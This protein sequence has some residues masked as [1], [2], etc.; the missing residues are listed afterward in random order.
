ML[1]AC[2]DC[3]G[4]LS[5][6]LI[7]GQFRTIRARAVEVAFLQPADT[8]GTSFHSR[9]VA[10][11][12]PSPQNKVVIQRGMLVAA[13]C[14]LLAGHLAAAEPAPLNR[15]F[16]GPAT[17]WELVDSAGMGRIQAQECVSGG[18][19]DASGAERLVVS[20]PPGQTV[21]LY[22]DVVPAA[23][24][25]ELEL[26]MW[27]KASLPNT[28]LAARIVLPRTATGDGKPPATVVVRGPKYVRAG[29]WQQLVFK[30][31]PKSLAAEVRFLRSTSGDKLETREAYLDAVFLLV[32]GERQG[33]EIMTDD[34]VIDGVIQTRDDNIKLTSY[35]ESRRTNATPMESVS[36]NLRRLPQA[37]AVPVVEKDSAICMRN[38]VLLVNDRPFMPRGIRWRGEPFATLAQMGFNTLWLDEMPSIEQSR[39]AKRHGVWFI[40]SPPRPEMLVGQ[41]LGSESDRILAWYLND[42][43]VEGDA[44]YASRWANGVRQYDRMQGR[45]ILMPPCVSMA[46][47]SSGDIL[48]APCALSGTLD[49][50]RYTSLLR[51]Y[52]KNVHPGTPMWPLL[53][54]QYGPSVAKQNA[55]L[56]HTAPMAPPSVS[57][58]QL[59][60]MVRLASIEGARGFVFDSESS[61][62]ETDPSTR[63]RAVQLELLNRD[64]Q[65]MEPWLASGKV[66][67]QIDSS[68]PAWSAMEFR[69]EQ[70]RLLVLMN[71]A[72]TGST[73]GE[74]ISFV[75][76]GIPE[77]CQVYLYTPVALQPL[78]VRRIAGGMQFTLKPSDST[79]VLLT[80]DMRVVQQLR[81]F[82][83]RY[84]DRTVRLERESAAISGKSLAET[85]HRLNLSGND[86]SLAQ[87]MANIN[88]LVA[89]GDASLAA[90]QLGPAHL[91][92]TNA[93]RQLEQS[94]REVRQAI[95]PTHIRLS[96]PQSVG[97]EALVQFVAFERSRPSLQLGE[98]LLYGGDFE[99]VGQLTQIGWQHFGR[100][101]AGV[102]SHVELSMAEPRHGKYALLM[103]A[104]A[105]GNALSAA[106]EPVSWIESPP[107]V[108]PEH[109]VIEISGF[110]RV[111]PA[112]PEVSETLR[113]LDSLGGT[114]LVL[115]VDRTN[116][117][118]RFS[119]IR[120]T[121]KLHELRLTFA[122]MSPGTVQLDAIMVRPLQIAPP[123]RLPALKPAGTNSPTAAAA[124]FVAPQQR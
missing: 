49:A 59:R 20:A 17:V 93:N 1:Y 25:E 75:V 27:I 98:N 64:L 83:A 61:L 96:H 62:A 123:Q 45:P 92:I 77:S 58:P 108:V 101:V 8:F 35:P 30:G 52:A 56:S 115:S 78:P 94:W 26:R 2:N 12:M 39:E 9:H 43:A 118:E 32:P 53:P 68:Q 34:L 21:Q 70:A 22:C 54:A 79:F 110:I 91:A 42:P 44:S 124:P 13:A 97:D 84:G 48:F 74:E 6:I 29:H 116:G 41:T 80:E 15:S 31:I 114:D 67:G 81:Q 24:L 86:Q 40:V 73:T 14:M 104:A 65:R 88:A 105:T 87:A 19:R 10:P 11:T 99:D 7:E 18:A 23:V 100:E 112:S 120:A 3:P 119:M 36:A 50:D 28:Q 122:L 57:L 121:D 109:A 4:S 117:W 38:N 66:L 90:N 37:G 69:V 76:P 60:E 85:A 113:I 71:K 63:K 47:T 5:E 89:Q 111:E 55:I 16:D 95:T 46:T 82:I 103:H 33:V 107:V 51:N 72:R 106:G 102:Q